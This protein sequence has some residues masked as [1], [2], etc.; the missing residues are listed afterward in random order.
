MDI[1]DN[2]AK[3]IIRLTTTSGGEDDDKDEGSDDAIVVQVGDIVTVT[4]ILRKEQRR[5][6]LQATTNVRKVL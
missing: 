3:L 1:T 6:F 2:G 5:T 4:G